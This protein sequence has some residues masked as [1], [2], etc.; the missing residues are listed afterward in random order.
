MQSNRNDNIVFAMSNVCKR[1]S[2]FI[3]FCGYAL[4]ASLR[5]PGNQTKKKFLGFEY[6][7]ETYARLTLGK[8]VALNCVCLGG[9]SRSKWS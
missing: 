9:V 1:A 4:T 5:F 8:I 6:T 7:I 3:A 2:P